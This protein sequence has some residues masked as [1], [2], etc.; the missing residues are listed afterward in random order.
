MI[1]FILSLLFSQFVTRCFCL[2]EWIRPASH[3]TVTNGSNYD[4]LRTSDLLADFNYN[5]S[6]CDT[7]K[8][9]SCLLPGENNNEYF[10]I[11][12]R[13]SKFCD[14]LSANKGLGDIDVETTRQYSWD[15]NVPESATY[16]ERVN[17]TLRFV[18]H[19]GKCVD[20]NQRITSWP[21]YM[22]ADT[23][24]TP[25]SISSSSASSS[26]TSATSSAS[27]SATSSS[28]SSSIPPSTATP[29]ST[30]A[31]IADNAPSTSR[32][33]LSTGAKAGIGAGIGGLAAVLGAAALVIF[34]QARKSREH[35]QSWFS[36]RVV[37]EKEMPMR[38]A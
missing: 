37:P 20:D 38:V 25:A 34:L 36:Q 21:F 7:T 12:S 11:D 35:A 32:T 19:N 29:T 28:E 30:T 5:C 9:D 10:K 18:P 8:V 17:W 33:G 26:S 23:T 22:K 4:T 27:L 16:I 3:E 13:C 24:V 15:V 31:P 14:R 1:V 2:D 6:A